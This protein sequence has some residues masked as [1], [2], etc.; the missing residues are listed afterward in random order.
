MPHPTQII[1]AAILAALS[2]LPATNPAT[3]P[4]PNF[5]AIASNGQTYRLSDQ[6]GKYVVLEWHDQTC[7]YVAKQYD[8]GNMQKLQKDWTA[9][10]VVWFTVVASTP[11]PP[12]NVTPQKENIYLATMHAA[13]T[14]ALMDFSG[15]LT[16][17]YHATTTPKCS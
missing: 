10:G 2:A 16:R 9:R 12:G 7:P 4:A 5:T 3:N 1:P 11:G 17:L 8:S 15:D 6:H 14:A 13:P